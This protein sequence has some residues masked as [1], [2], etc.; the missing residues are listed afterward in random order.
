MFR[1]VRFFRQLARGR[2]GA[3]AI[4]YGFLIG[5]IS[6]TLLGVITVLGESVVA[7]FEGVTSDIP[8]AEAIA[9][10]AQGGVEGNCG[11]GEGEGSAECENK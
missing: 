5:L 6:I 9:A 4:E 1:F 7:L 2:R 11:D 10:K 8:T 3:T